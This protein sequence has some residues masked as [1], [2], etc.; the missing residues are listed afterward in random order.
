MPRL[1]RSPRTILLLLPF[2]LALAW[3]ARGGPD[4]APVA[5]AAGPQQAA[6][7]AIEP[8]DYPPLRPPEARNF[9]SGL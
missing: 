7:A 1:L 5:P 8:V 6:T 4:P 9:P 3:L 2:A